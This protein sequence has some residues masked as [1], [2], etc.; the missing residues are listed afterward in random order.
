MR[1]L[2][3]AL[4]AI[5]CTQPV[6]ILGP[7]ERSIIGEPFA[8]PQPQ[9]EGQDPSL[10]DDELEIFYVVGNIYTARRAS[11][12]DPWSAPEL[13]E[14]LRAGTT[15]SDP[16]VSGDGL[17]IYFS[18]YA[19][20]ID[21]TNNDLFVSTRPNRDPATPWSTPIHLLELSSPARDCCTAVN[22]DQTEVYFASERNLY[23][24]PDIFFSH[25]SDTTAAWS[26]PVMVPELST[27]A[28]DLPS[29]VRAPLLLFDSNR[30]TPERRIFFATRLPNGTHQA[31]LVDSIDLGA[32]ARDSWLSPDGHRIYFE[33]EA[34]GTRTIYVAER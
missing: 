1:S 11:R 27:G 21:R 12:T 28:Y 2:L 25:R 33:S 8:A 30:S 16:R 3:A 22:A 24:Y 34:A 7:S 20:P 15:T 17:T 29:L 5:G 14:S 26:L 9:L 18:L 13:V 4:L 31:V 10:T 32:D 23:G 19:D 6:T